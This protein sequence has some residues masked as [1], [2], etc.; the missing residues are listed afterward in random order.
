[1]SH[2]EQIEFFTEV[3]NANQSLIAGASVL[4]IGSYNVNGTIR[5]FFSS[6]SHY[7]GVDLTE[8]PG[9]DRVGYGHELDYPDGYFD[10]VLSGECFEH[11]PHWRDTFNNM[12]RMT[13]LGGLVAFTCASRGRLE[14][15]TTR[16]CKASSPGTQ[17]VG[18]DYYRNLDARDF[19]T[20]PLES[21]FS[22]YRFWY[23]PTHHDLYFA[24]IRRGEG[25]KL[26]QLPQGTAVDRLR[27]L[28]PL[29]KRIV[30]AGMRSLAWALPQAQYQTVALRVKQACGRAG[31]AKS[32]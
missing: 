31:G 23:L 8:G 18:L 21:M 25:E 4:E 29:Q 22:E 14:H 10:I 2:V 6:A 24:G 26:A 17:A 16:T 12:A 15:G 9:V 1:M 3:A 11:D 27:H 13:K 19:Q 30:H 7:T 28:M 5:D 20:L 32:S